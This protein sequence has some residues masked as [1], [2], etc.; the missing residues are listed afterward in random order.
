M[1]DFFGDDA[2][3]QFGQRRSAS[4]SRRAFAEKL[5]REANL[6]PAP[7]IQ[8]TAPPP[9]AVQRIRNQVL[10]EFDDQ[11][12]VAVPGAPR[13]LSFTL[14]QQLGIAVEYAPVPGNVEAGD[15]PEARDD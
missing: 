13:R 14:A 1:P 5:I 12:F 10:A 9:A 6:Q 4:A 3:D 8:E 11:N 15:D 2:F 7:V